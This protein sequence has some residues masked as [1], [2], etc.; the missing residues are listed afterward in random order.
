[1]ANRLSA[2]TNLDKYATV[3]VLRG[4]GFFG[5]SVA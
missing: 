1:M 5:P 2:H 3:D 4:S